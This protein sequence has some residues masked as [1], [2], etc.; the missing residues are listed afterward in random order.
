MT[1]EMDSW[2]SY[3]ERTYIGSTGRFGRRLR[4]RIPLEQWSMYNQVKNGVPVTNN[5][6]EA[7]NGAWNRSTPPNPSLWTVITG[8]QR[9]EGLAYHK[10]Q[11]ERRL[12]RH[13]VQEDPQEGSSRK[14][15]SKD[16]VA[17]YK[18]LVENYEQFLDK[19]NYLGEISRL[20]EM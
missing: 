6:V 8:F 11:E 14:I 17:R 10:V 20:S 18:L 4:P 2:M 1:E 19:R 12:I 16:K 5:A 9:E 3:F 13:D 7:H 15:H